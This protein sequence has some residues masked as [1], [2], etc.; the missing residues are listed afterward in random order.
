M[1]PTLG[2]KSSIRSI[3]RTEIEMELLRPSWWIELTGLEVGRVIEMEFPELQ[4]SGTARVLGMSACP[5]IEEGEGRVVIGRFVTRAASNLLRVTLED[6]SQFTGTTNHPVWSID[7]ND[8]KPLEEMTPSERLLTL[9][10]ETRIASVDTVSSP[11]DVFNI[12]VHGAHVYRILSGGLLVHN[13]ADYTN[14]IN[15]IKGLFHLYPRVVDTRTGRLIPFPSSL[16]RR[17]GTAANVHPPADK[18]AFIAEWYQRGLP[19]PDRPWDELQLHHIHP[20]EW[21][22]DNDFWNLV[23]LPIETHDYF[24]RF[25]DILRSGSG[26]F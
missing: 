17:A 12:E 6:G 23:P 18:G 24:S 16:F 21:G 4:T 10:G 7:A 26:T 1:I 11:A 25:W 2:L 15:S 22:G 9:S 14:M 5:A 8:W 3:S 13:A 19:S 20:R